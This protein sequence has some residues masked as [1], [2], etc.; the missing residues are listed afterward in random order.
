[1][2][3]RKRIQAKTFDMLIVRAVAKMGIEMLAFFIIHH[4]RQQ[5][6]IYKLY[7]KGEWEDLA[8]GSQVAR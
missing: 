5:W 1:M 4:M 6:H 2:F 3:G 7:G 8:S